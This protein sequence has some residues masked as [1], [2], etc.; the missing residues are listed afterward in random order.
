MHLAKIENAS[1][2][3]YKSPSKTDYRSKSRVRQQEANYHN[4]RNTKPK[5][6]PLLPSA[7]ALAVAAAANLDS[8]KRWG[9]K[10]SN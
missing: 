2:D 9:V 8:S 1:R 4:L 7:G 5:L 3:L 10:N 6:E